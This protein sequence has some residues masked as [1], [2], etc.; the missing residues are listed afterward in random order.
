MN[1]NDGKG[2]TDFFD[3]PKEELDL[4]AKEFSEG[5]ENLEE[6]LKTL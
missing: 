5:N 1:Y 6:L 3:K 2:H 4:I